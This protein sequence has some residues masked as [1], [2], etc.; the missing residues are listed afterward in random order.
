MKDQYPGSNDEYGM[1]TSGLASNYLDQSSST[2]L[3][4][5]LRDLSYHLQAASK[6][7]D[8][9]SN[10][11]NII[12][13]PPTPHQLPL[14]PLSG[15][16][17]YSRQPDVPEKTAFLQRNRLW[18][19]KQRLRHSKVEQA[20]KTRELS[21]CTFKPTVNARSAR[22]VEDLEQKMRE[23]QGE[24]WEVVSGVMNGDS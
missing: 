22:I 13:P 14:P 17:P 10:I 12:R 15:I 4:S 1:K 24:R 21:E 11:S 5:Y 7:K 8:A 20:L 3:P 16:S 6:H 19:N 18:V 2:Q 23:S 9:D